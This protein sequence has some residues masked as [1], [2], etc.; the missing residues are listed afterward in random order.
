MINHEINRLIN[1]ALQNSSEKAHNL[2]KWEP[3]Y[4]NV[5]D[6]IKTA[7]TWHSKNPDG[8]ND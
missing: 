6:I 1:F 4:T 2:L 7:W 3:K 8:F 5:K